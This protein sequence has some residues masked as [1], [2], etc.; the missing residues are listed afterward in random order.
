MLV[1]L[2]LSSNNMNSENMV[3][4]INNGTERKYLPSKSKAVSSISRTKGK[5]FTYVAT[6]PASGK[7]T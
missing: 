3:L 2:K 1:P 7:M 4:K 6:L 5:N